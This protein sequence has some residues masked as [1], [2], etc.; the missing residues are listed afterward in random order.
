MKV[1]PQLSSPTRA[2]G[3]TLSCSLRA[4]AMYVKQSI[5]IQRRDGRMFLSLLLPTLCRMCFVMML[6]IK[7]WRSTGLPSIK[8]SPSH[9][10]RSLMRTLMSF[11]MMSGILLTTWKWGWEKLQWRQ[12]KMN[13]QWTKTIEEVSS[14]Q[15]RS[16]VLKKRQSRTSLSRTPSKLR[17]WKGSMHSSS[18]FLNL[19]WYS[20][21]IKGRDK[22]RT[23]ARE[24][25]IHSKK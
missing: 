14:Q 25:K 22:R 11:H 6:K 20:N 23:I 7:I 1:L 2:S 3:M 13:W 8:G 17:L 4:K 19:S 5:S 12:Q 10:S 16:S 9:I 18:R 15:S 21:S 24:K